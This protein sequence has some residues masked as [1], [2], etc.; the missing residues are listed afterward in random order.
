MKNGDAK[1][2]KIDELNKIVDYI[3][4]KYIVEE[5][6]ENLREYSNEYK[7]YHN[8]DWIREQIQNFVNSIDDEDAFEL[9][10][11]LPDDVFYKKVNINGEVSVVDIVRKNLADALY[12]ELAWEVWSAIDCQLNP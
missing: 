6:I 4:D 1:M 3:W 11:Y 9:S 5:K 12:K 8:C 10:E 7:E 2:E